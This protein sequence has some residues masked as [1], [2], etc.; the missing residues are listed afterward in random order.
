MNV[1]E[2]PPV[3]DIEAFCKE[4][5][6]LGYKNNH[7]L[8]A[9]KHEWCLAEGGNWWAAY[10]D[11]NMVSIAGCHPFWDGYRVMFRG[12]QTEQSGHGLSKKHLT[13][14]PWK[15][16]M[17]KQ[18]E[19]CHQTNKVPLYITTNTSHDE[20]GKMNRTHRILKLLADQGIVDYV[21]DDEIFYTHQS[22]WE[23]NTGK[24]YETL[25]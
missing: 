15:T 2:N 20:S 17:P 3:F 1:V 10:R 18:I 4:C 14:I 12:A 5:D 8:K 25:V 24:Y 11:N 22:V 21:C 19:W 13:S 6:I 16:L 23:L 7:T 9:M